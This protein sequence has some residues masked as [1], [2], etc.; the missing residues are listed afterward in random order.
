ML[1]YWRFI[2]LCNGNNTQIKVLLVKKLLLKLVLSLLPI[3]VLAAFVIQLHPLVI[4]ESHLEAKNAKIAS[5]KA[6]AIWKQFS[7]TQTYVEIELNTDAINAIAEVASHTFDNTKVAIRFNRFLVIIASTI[8]L[9]PF[10]INFNCTLSQGASVYQIDGCYFGNLYIPGFIINSTM[11]FGAWL[12]FDTDVSETVA[13]LLTNIQ[14]SD[15]KIILSTTKSSD[16]KDSINS[17][18]KGIADIAKTVSQSANVAPDKI[19]QYLKK[20]DHVASK[21]N[22]LSNSVTVVMQQ[23]MLNSIDGNPVEENTAALWAL[24]IKFGSLKF[25]RLAGIDG[26]IQ[27]QSMTLGG[28]QD[29]SLHFLYSA[30]LQQVGRENIG[31]KIGEF[32]E[33]LDSAKGGSGFSF[34]D[35]AADKAG[36]VFAEYLTRSNKSALKAQYILA[37]HIDESIFF[38]FIHDLPEGIRESDFTRVLEGMYSESYNE[39]AAN[40]DQRIAGLKLYSEAD[41]EAT[42]AFDKNNFIGPVSTLGKWLKI[43]THIHTRY[44]DGNKT[45]SEVAKNAHKFGCDVIAITDHGDKE[46]TKVLSEEYFAEIDKVSRLYPQMNI[47]PGFEWNI[48][49]FGGREHA[50]VLF[51]DTPAMKRQLRLFR[52]QFDHYKEYKTQ[53]LSSKPAF[54]WLNALAEKDAEKPVIIY[55]HPSRKDFQ[56]AENQYDMELWAQETDVVIGFSGAPGH[57]RKRG[58]NNGSYQSVLRTIHGWDPSIA[59]IGGEWDK[60]LQSGYRITAAR[61]ASNFHNVQ[62]DYWPCQFSSTHLFSESNAQNDVLMAMRQGKMWAQHGKFVESLMFSVNN[63]KGKVHN[64]GSVAY[65]SQIG[66][67]IKINLEVNLA[68]EDWQGFETSL[69]E[70]ELI[71]ITQ[72]SITT[73]PISVYAN[74]TGKRLSFE[75]SQIINSKHTVVRI[76]GRSIQPEMHHYMFYTNPIYIRVRDAN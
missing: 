40:I 55:N 36:L 21:S 42:D 74:M 27:Q 25:A 3:I 64:I 31:L 16:F 58:R 26:D 17:S 43:D 19:E 46:L 67:N 2:S 56:T 57:Q 62:M 1:A 7:S 45:V 13:Q 48:P 33:I 9:K 4:Q 66:E 52:E 53:F 60:L 37:N 72:D 61:A 51:A 68:S 73:T 70:L 12:L 49:P 18:L 24:A 8:D 15:E 6:K 35:L 39:L 63:K 75:T 11:R 76:S 28:R 30:M 69:D 5:K 54:Q 23:A 20:L 44:S 65:V 50:T 59:I 32:K 10:Y 14:V 38:P 71:I 41:N 34:A 29:L 47:I 22:S